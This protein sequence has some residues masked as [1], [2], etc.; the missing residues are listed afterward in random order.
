MDLVFE[1]INGCGKSTL[2]AELSKR[3]EKKGTPTCTVSSIKSKTAK[4]IKQT[5]IFREEFLDDYLLETTLVVCERRCDLSSRVAHAE[6][7]G[8]FER[9]LPSLKAIGAM[10]GLDP[11]ELQALIDLVIPDFPKNRWVLVDIDAELAAN[12]L[13]TKDRHRFEDYSISWYNQL[14]SHY[15][16]LADEDA[17]HALVV[18][19][20]GGVEEVIDNIINEFF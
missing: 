14:R 16:R 15:L 9:G 17:Q 4:S 13:R 20:A 12:R 1:G 19:G 2:I 11:Q 7:I 18:D 8:L 5:N 6:K 3:L 10:R